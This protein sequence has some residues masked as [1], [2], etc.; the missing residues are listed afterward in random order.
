MPHALVAPSQLVFPPLIPRVRN[1]FSEKDL[2][3]KGE[4]LLKITQKKSRT[5]VTLALSG[6]LDLIS[7]PSFKK[8]L[9][10]SFREK[11]QSLTVDLKELKT[12]DS[13]GIGLL[14]LAYAMIQDKKNIRVIN[15]NA[16]V[17][18]IFQITHLFQFFP[19]K[20]H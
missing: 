19:K 13:V 15:T 5:H 2:V 6:S 4:H 7:A 1:D 10:R 16:Y 11:F 18:R 14:L 20:K 12:I 9:L 8:I 17:S 3:E